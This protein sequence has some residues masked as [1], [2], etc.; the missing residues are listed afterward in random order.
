MRAAVG[1]MVALIASAALASA[2]TPN[3]VHADHAAHAMAQTPPAGGQPAMPPPPAQPVPKAANLPA[4]EAGAKDAIAKTPRHTEY[5]D[6]KVE[7][8][9]TPVKTFVVYPERKDKAPVV[10]VIQEIFG[11]SDWIKGVAD[12]LAQE[13]FIAVAPDLLSGLGPNNGGTE[14]FASRDDVV[15]AV[16]K[17]TPPDVVAMLNGVRAYA[18]KLPSATG[19]SGSVGFCWGGG[20]SFLYATAQ[21]DLNAAVVYY[22]TSPSA[23]ALATIK[24]PVLG[25]YGG[26]DARVNA[27]IEPAS[28]KLKELG[29]T[30][31]PHIYDGAGHG[32]LRQQGGQNGANLKATQE[33]WPAT[34]AFLKNHTK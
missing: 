4:D 20:M 33:A 29:K 21:P 11:L 27:T 19:K 7:G 1:A 9:A 2:Q 10:L 22:G 5:V 16:R 28:A 30:Y 26:N 15:A 24:A 13:G 34:I 31:E 18:V 17:L 23:D 3:D 32:F 14:A 8:R 25:L 12:Q 6:V